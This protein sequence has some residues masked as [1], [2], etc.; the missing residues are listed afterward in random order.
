MTT[1]SKILALITTA[2]C[3]AFLGFVMVSLIAG[4]NWQG[5]TRN[6]LFADYTFENSGGEKPTWSAKRR[7]TDQAVGGASPVLAKKLV[8]VLGEIKQQQ[9]QRITVLDQG[10][11]ATK[12]VGIEGLD[13]YINDPNQGLRALL[14]KDIEA[15]KQNH[16]RLQNDLAAVQAE[17]EKATRDV[18]DTIN[19]IESTYIKAERRRGDIY[20]LGNVVAESETDRYRAIEHQVKLRDVWQRYQGLIE[21]LEQRKAVLERQLKQRPGYESP[22]AVNVNA[23]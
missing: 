15:L 13:L 11:A 3:L 2:A 5:E 9:Q 21:R 22:P 14:Y 20:R 7:N 17:I 1:F 8:D 18:T 10:D 19:A 16:A 23:S 12:T 6:E 4:P